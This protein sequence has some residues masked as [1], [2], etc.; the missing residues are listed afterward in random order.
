MVEPKIILPRGRKD[1]PKNRFLLTRCGLCKGQGRVKLTKR[2]TSAWG[3][4]S[5]TCPE[6]DGY[7][8]VKDLT[9]RQNKQLER[10]EGF[11]R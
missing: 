2:Q 6:C 3:Y 10:E 5:L 9:Y 1:A 11:V 8:Y 7:G 4:D